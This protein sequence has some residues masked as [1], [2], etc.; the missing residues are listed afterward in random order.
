MSRKQVAI[1]VNTG[2]ASGMFDGP[3]HLIL[4]LS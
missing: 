4:A 2:H 3:E 1:I